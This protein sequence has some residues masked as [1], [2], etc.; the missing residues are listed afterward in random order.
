MFGNN[1]HDQERENQRREGA[2]LGGVEGTLK[3]RDGFNQPA[4]PVGNHRPS[5][6]RPSGSRPA[7]NRGGA[8]KGHDATL[9]QWQDG[10]A[11]VLVSLIDG[12]EITGTVTDSDRYTVTITTGAVYATLVYKHAIAMIQPTG[13][14]PSGAQS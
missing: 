13:V 11:Y 7:G 3:V 2:K 6:S 5:G 9:K 8:P 14:E 12:A 4:R 1:A 10:G